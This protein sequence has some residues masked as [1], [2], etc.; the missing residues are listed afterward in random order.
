MLGPLKLM[1]SNLVE[2]SAEL[3]FWDEFIEDDLLTYESYSMGINA[4]KISSMEM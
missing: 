2:Y 3:M 1:H 4:I